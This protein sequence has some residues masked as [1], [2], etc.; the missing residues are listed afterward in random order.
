LMARLAPLHPAV[1]TLPHAFRTSLNPHSLWAELKHLT[2]WFNHLTAAGVTTLADVDQQHC[3]RYLAAVSRSITDPDRLLSPATTTAMVRVPQLLA[4]YA[5][6][7][8]DSYRPGF[9][10]WAGR[11]ADEVAGY[12]RTNVNR[13][14]PVPDSLLRPLLMNSLYLLETISPH[15]VLDAQAV[16]AADQHEAASR[17]GLRI[18]EIPKMRAAI[19]RRRASNVPAPLISTGGLGKRLREGWDPRDPLLQMAWHPVVL[20]VASAMGHR[21]SLEILRP[22]LER[23]VQK[24]GVQEPWCR[25]PAEVPRQDTAELVPWTR[26]MSRQRLDTTIYAV[27]SAAFALTS[28][29]SGMR[30]SELAELSAGCS[31]QEERHGGAN[32][33]RLVTRRIKGEPFGGTED[34]W[35]VIEDVYRAIGAAQALTGA[36]TGDLLFATASNNSAAR[37]RVLREW[38]RGEAGQRL[39]LEPIPD[40]PVNPRALRRTLAMTIAQRPHGLMAAKVHLKHVSVATTEGYTARPGGHQAAF[41]AEITAEEE[42]EHLRLTVAAYQDYQRGDLPSGPGARDLIASF[43]AA[44]QVLDRHDPGPVTVIDDRRVERILKAQAKSLHL[45]VGN[46]CWFTDP[47]KALC[48]KVAGTPDAA[49]PLIGM[50]DSA[51]CPQATHHPQHRQVWADHAETTRAVFLGNPTLSKPERARAQATFDRATR[52]VA[53]IDTTSGPT[54]EGTSHGA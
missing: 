40:G 42:A 54:T 3:D 19:E 50:C 51:R 34:A 22:E 27:V 12:S 49:E 11:S 53:E 14:P 6:I 35:V 52:I 29:L 44:D 18:G 39:G 24:C 43:Q 28:A 37:F 41:T 48:L 5:E 32:R 13:V 46:Y 16:L 25:N 1:A 45:G 31:R 15:L 8:S 33:F 38:I 21:R 10:P 17:R 9:T 7:L 20:E 2:S 4:L 47:S 36:A 26:P 30:S 23:W